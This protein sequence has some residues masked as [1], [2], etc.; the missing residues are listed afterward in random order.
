[1]SVKRRKIAWMLVFA[2]LLTSVPMGWGTK[3]AKAYM[4]EVDKSEK[5]SEKMMEWTYHLGDNSSDKSVISFDEP[6]FWMSYISIESFSITFNQ[7]NILNAFG[8][9]D[10]S[11]DVYGEE[12]E[13]VWYEVSEDGTQTKLAEGQR[14]DINKMAT[15]DGPQFQWHYRYIGELKSINITSAGRCRFEDLED[16]DTNLCKLQY[17]I[18]VKY[19]GPIAAEI[20]S[21]KAKLSQYVRGL[22]DLKDDMYIYKDKSQEVAER[23]YYNESTSEFAT[24]TTI[25]FPNLKP[26]SSYTDG[27]EIISKWY[28]YSVDGDKL[29]LTSKN[30]TGSGIEA[31]EA[32][33]NQEFIEY[34]DEGKETGNFISKMVDYYQ[35]EYVI[36]HGSQLL[37]QGTKNIDLMLSP[38]KFAPSVEKKK[39]EATL[40]CSVSLEVNTEIYDTEYCSGVMYQWYAIKKGEKEKLQGETSPKLKTYIKDFETGYLC[41]IKG[42]YRDGYQGSPF[43]EQSQFQIIEDSGYVIRGISNR[44]KTACIGEEVE[45]YIDA[46]VNE[47]YEL[48]Y[49]WEKNSRLGNIP[50]EVIG[51]NSSCMVSLNSKDYSMGI[52]NLHVMVSKSGEVISEYDYKFYITEKYALEIDSNDSVP[53]KIYPGEDVRFFAN[54]TC[55][56]YIVC[57]KKWGMLIE[58]SAEVKNYSYNSSTGKYNCTFKEDYTEPEYDFCRMIHENEGGNYHFWIQYYQE[59]QP[60]EHGNLTLKGKDEDGN[61]ILHETQAACQVK[62]GIQDENGDTIKTIYEVLPFYLEYQSDLEAYAKE[63]NPVAALGEE[64]ELEVMVNATNPENDELEFTWEKFNSITGKWEVLTYEDGE[65]IEETWYY[66]E[67]IHSEDFGMYRFTVDDRITSKTVFLR[68]EEKSYE[69]QVYTPKEVTYYSNIGKEVSLQLDYD[70]EKEANAFF[71]WYRLEERYQ[72]TTITQKEKVWVQIQNQ[73]DDTYRF[74]ADALEDFRDYKCVMTYKTLNS[75]GET[76]LI[77]QE[78]IFHLKKEGNIY[79]NYET[80]MKEKKKLGKS[81]EYKVSVLS[82]ISGF[83][84]SKVSYQWYVNDERIEAVKGNAYV[85]E[86]LQGKDFGTIK[87]WASYVDDS[88]YEYTASKEFITELYV[89]FTVKNNEETKYVPLGE[90]VLLEPQIEG[91]LPEGLTY[92]WYFHPQFTPVNYQD[93]KLNEAT[94]FYYEI[95]SVGSGQL[96][97]YY[98][99]AKLDGVECFTYQCYLNEEQSNILSVN[100]P[101]GMQ[102]E[103]YAE[104]GDSVTLEVN[105]ESTKNLTLKYQWYCAKNEEAIGGATQKKYT[106]T[107]FGLESG[108]IS[109]GYYCIVTDSEGNK[110]K[111]SYEVYHVN[112]LEIIT[113][114]YEDNEY[115]GYEVDFGED[116][117]LVAN[118]SVGNDKKIYYQWGKKTIDGIGWKDLYDETESELSIDSISQ[119]DIGDYRCVVSDVEGNQKT[120][121]YRLYADTGLQV[122]PG[123]YYP[124]V[125]DDGSIMMYVRATAKE[126][127]DISYQWSKGRFVYEGEEEYN[128]ELDV[129]DDGK[130][131]VYDEISQA[132]S[133]EYEREKLYKADYGYYQVKVSTKGESETYDFYLGAKYGDIQ[134]EKDFVQSGDEIVLQIP[135]VNAAV[136]ENYTYEWYMEDLAMGAYQ[137][138]Q[139]AQPE[140]VVSIPTIKNKRTKSGYYELGFQCK[141]KDG[142][143]KILDNKFTSVKLLNTVEFSEELPESTHPFDASYDLKGYRKEGAKRLT[144]TFDVS[145]DLGDEELYI[146]DENGAYK[147]YGSYQAL[148]TEDGSKSTISIEGDTAIFLLTGN[149]NVDSYGYKVTEVDVKMPEDPSLPIPTLTPTSTPNN[150]YRPVITP[151]AIEIPIPDNTDKSVVTGGSVE[152]VKN[153]ICI[154]LKE[155]VSIKIAGASYNSNKKKTVKVNK[156]GKITGLK[157]G[158]ATVTAITKEKKYIYT[159][160]VKKAPKKIKKINPKKLNLSP[161]K[162]AQLKVVLPKGSASYQITYRSSD[163]KIATVTKNGVVKAKK[164]GTCKIWASTYNG[165]KKTIIV[166][167]KNK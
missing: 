28:A 61:V 150:A 92:Q 33:I 30:A 155:K 160:V 38:V 147:N 106:I 40:N 140:I 14:L 9:E 49:C 136:D 25:S 56:E 105:A 87:V 81:R 126:G 127:Y 36:R 99:I 8:I 124:V 52:Y 78:F 7:K 137:K 167:V 104:Y 31:L 153:K 112:S 13:H 70:L 141:I 11:F 57:E 48:S 54:I 10:E 72:N 17:D 18:I 120:L 157:R 69:S 66:I 16:F 95:D 146:I 6:E 134:Q 2:M 34:D 100:Y 93:I 158:K 32:T 135:I 139:G 73:E 64:I 114:E 123:A 83:D 41:E 21:G 117:T 111:L 50:S 1:M 119:E 24:D 75:S 107:C 97:R 89:D 67:E 125:R 15:N 3:K 113:P 132:D 74:I 130:H 91:E 110:K 152:V 142:E 122:V 88:G 163:K 71:E 45:L 96:G 103:I 58:T 47:G 98:C 37:K 79:L 108:S 94:D 53:H 165:K 68:L 4:Y 109:N 46:Q 60:D 43:T 129:D 159:V 145:S 151:G 22:D 115:W 101:E 133:P 143:G 102:K 138:I 62:Y 27:M 156:N 76:I 42:K 84:E 131:L 86:A 90:D 154:G 23:N 26:Y 51:T 5:K 128:Q 29:P 65:P 166:N 118:A 77:S 55:P 20:N 85:V 35:C 59:V 80:L 63:D 164:K 12:I 148:C 149:D 82:D 39:I 144:F 161:K 116:I 121:Y 19:T 44:D 162:K